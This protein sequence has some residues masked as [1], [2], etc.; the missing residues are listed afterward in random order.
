MLRSFST[1]ATAAR[2]FLRGFG[3][4]P[5]ALQRRDGGVAVEIGAS[6]GGYQRNLSSLISFFLGAGDGTFS[7]GIAQTFS[8]RTVSYP[9]AIAARTSLAVGCWAWRRGAGKRHRGQ[10]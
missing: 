4:R 1:P 5:A 9:Q 2:V 8:A 7:N 3:V 10:P 6:L